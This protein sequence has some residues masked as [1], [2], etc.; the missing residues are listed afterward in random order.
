RWFRDSD[1][2]GKNDLML[3]LGP[4][5][6][7]NDVNNAGQVVGAS[8]GSSGHAFLWQNGTMT[9]LGTLGGSTT[10]PN[11]INHA[12]QVPGIAA[13]PTGA[14]DAFLWPGGVMH[15]LGAADAANDVNQAGQVVGAGARFATLWTPT[16][17]NGTTGS[18]QTLDTIP[19]GLD[20][21][22]DG[23]ILVS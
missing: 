2:D 20:G 3:D 15:A 1:G 18:F 8:Y 7:A 4:N 14:I 21:V 6:I 11:A 22:E 5:S 17:P 9:D 19:R 13:T 12:G 23:W 10:S 16:T